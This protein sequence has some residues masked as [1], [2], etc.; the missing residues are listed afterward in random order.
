MLT[1]SAEYAEVS[2]FQS[3]IKY[4]E[5]RDTNG[6][7]SL[8]LPSYW[9]TFESYCLLIRDDADILQISYILYGMNWASEIPLIYI[10]NIGFT[11]ELF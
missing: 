10:K 9:I 8:T 6:I 5:L 1:T 7:W 3:N 11:R 2:Y 4:Y